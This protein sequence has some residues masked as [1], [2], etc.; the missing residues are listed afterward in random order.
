M[1]NPQKTWHYDEVWWELFETHYPK[2]PT[3]ADA[4]KIYNAAYDLNQLI[5]QQTTI[6]DFVDVTMTTLRVNEKYLP[7]G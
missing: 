6:N 2:N 5:A 3:E 7:L 1:S 4:K